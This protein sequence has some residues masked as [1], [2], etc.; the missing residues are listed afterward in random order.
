MSMFLNVKRGIKKFLVYTN[1]N[2]HSF[3]QFPNILK[4]LRFFKIRFLP[5]TSLNRLYL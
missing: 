1:N 5:N 4:T 2:N 3:F